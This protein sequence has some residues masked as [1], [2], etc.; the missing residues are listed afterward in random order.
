M[1]GHD[2]I[3]KLV[4][5]LWRT[6]APNSFD[7]LTGLFCSFPNHDTTETVIL[8]FAFCKQNYKNAGAEIA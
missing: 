1:G 6:I 5:K 7:W 4:L 2:V 3:F 8:K